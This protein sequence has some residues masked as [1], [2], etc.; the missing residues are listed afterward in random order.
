MADRSGP[1]P[2]D[3]ASLTPV[4][5]ERVAGLTWRDRLLAVRDRIVGDRR[6]QRWAAGFPLTRPIA[7]RQA[8]AL[9]DL[10]AGFVYSQVLL[11]VVRLGLLDLVADRPLTSE[12][13]AS[14]TGLASDPCNR[15]LA[16]AAALD[17]LSRRSS[18]R[19]GLGMLGAALRANPGVAAM[20][21]HHG[22]LYA[23]LVDPVGLLRRD[24]AAT[25][26]GGYWPYASAENPASL[27]GDATAAYTALMA[28]SQDLIADDIIEAYPLQRHRR[29]LDVGGGDGTFLAAVARHVPNLDLVLFDLPAVAERARTRFDAA[30]SP[31]RLTIAAGSFLTDDLPAGA[32]V[33]TLVR[34]ILDHDD[35]TVLHVLRAIRR[36]IAPGGTLL[37]AEPLSGVRGV[38]RTSDAYFG[39]YLMAMGRGRPR[40][41]AD[42]TRLLT[43]AGFRAPRLLRTRRPMLTSVIQARTD[44]QT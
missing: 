18:G 7:R 20:I 39:I 23:D 25:R 41:Y 42:I 1:G 22:A 31:A 38:E 16:A 19:Y 26:L 2:R 30:A 36:A 15:L 3:A 13:I 9:F 4:L 37:V 17:L 11:S 43:A 6:F 32:D 28:A 33:V 27:P 40:S 10:C 12:D 21:E 34:V 29:L 14:R 44:P 24:K 8:Q 5:G 35:D